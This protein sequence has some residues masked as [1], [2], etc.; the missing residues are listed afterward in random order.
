[1]KK[2]I[3][4]FCLISMA[5][6]S[7][8][9]SNFHRGYVIQHDGDTLI[10]YINAGAK[11][12]CKFKLDAI[13]K[14]VTEYLPVAVKGY[15][16]YGGK[17]FESKAVTNATGETESQFV[18]C[19]VHGKASV[20]QHKKRYFIEA[21]DT[22][23]MEL[24][25]NQNILTNPDKSIRESSYYKYENKRYVGVLNHLLRDCPEIL[26]KTNDVRLNPKDLSSLLVE[27]N[28]C[29][30]EQF[31]HYQS[32]RPWVKVSF[33]SSTG[34]VMSQLKLK[35]HNYNN[36][37]VNFDDAS[38]SI[39]PMVGV[40]GFFTWPK[41]W[42]RL[43][44]SVGLHYFKTDFQIS[45]QVENSILVDYYDGAV[46]TTE[47][48][49]P[50]GLH[51]SLPE[52][53]FTPY[54]SGGLSYSFMLDKSARIHIERH[55]GGTVQVRDT[56]LFEFQPMNFGFWLGLGTNYKLS[57]KLELFGE[58]RYEIATS[59]SNSTYISSEYSHMFFILGMKFR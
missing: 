28:Q 24:T 11:P 14:K 6:C 49:I 48:K 27:Y 23:F 15:G 58:I 13:T 35:S 3:L 10:G 43:S 55:I 42:S 57:G 18:E 52:K 56:N 46:K 37:F 19:L 44:A 12:S 1:M 59:L 22:T 20:Y 33:G 34:L 40:T 29:Q 4:F 30:D 45:S 8:G 36:E 53:K 26:Q 7:F 25:S 39:S 50:I 41:N 32:D 5:I 16:I 17:Y 47:I 9:Q 2:L 31:I 38:N 54:A 21:N 51:Y